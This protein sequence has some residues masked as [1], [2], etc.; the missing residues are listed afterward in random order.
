[1]RQKVGDRQK[2]E[3]W[4][5]DES[6]LCRDKKMKE[7]VRMKE[8]GRARN[9]KLDTRSKEGDKKSRRTETERWN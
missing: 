8:K 2:I 5:K 7:R 6:V 4:V 3:R 1:M 9:T